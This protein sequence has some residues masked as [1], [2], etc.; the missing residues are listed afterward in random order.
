MEILNKGS[1]MELS[2]TDIGPRGLKIIGAIIAAGESFDPM[3]IWCELNM[4][5]RFHTSQEKNEKSVI[6]MNHI[7]AI[8][9]KLTKHE[10]FYVTPQKHG[11]KKIVNAGRV[12]MSSSAGVSWAADLN[13]LLEESKVEGS[14]FCTYTKSFF[15]VYRRGENF[16]LLLYRLAGAFDEE[17]LES[18]AA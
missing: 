16:N 6:S 14:M 7:M 3:E 11:Y 8:F 13:E 17:L 12:M 5:N 1:E 4:V 10:A 18:E 15:D 2:R 9:R